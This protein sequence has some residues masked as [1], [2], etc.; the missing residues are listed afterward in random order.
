MKKRPKIKEKIS[1]KKLMIQ[2]LQMNSCKCYYCWLIP[3]TVINWGQSCLRL[4]S[5][6]ESLPK[7]MTGFKR[8]NIKVVTVTID[9][10]LL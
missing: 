6:R 4:K 5:L 10:Y 7:T 1:D 3:A 2:T 9:Q 8:V